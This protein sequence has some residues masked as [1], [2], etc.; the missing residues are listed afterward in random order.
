MK[1]TRVQLTLRSA[2][3]GR[4]GGMTTALR[5]AALAFGLL[6]LTAGGLQLWAHAAGGGVRHLV[7]GIFATAVGVSVFAA[8]VSEV[9]ARR[10]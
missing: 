5:A 10:R 7:L 2:T 9:R 4:L 8:V 3:G 1:L 6:A